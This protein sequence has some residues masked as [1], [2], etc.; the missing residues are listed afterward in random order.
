VEK[1]ERNFKISFLFSRFLRPMLL[2]TTV[3]M[4]SKF[5]QQRFVIL[6]ESSVHAHAEEFQRN[7]FQIVV[8]GDPEVGKSTYLK[9]LRTKEFDS[10]RR[11]TTATDLVIYYIMLIDSQRYVKM[12]FFDMVGQDI[13][14]PDDL[15]PLL[16]KSDAV[17]AFFDA[18][19]PKTFENLSRWKVRLDKTIG[20]GEYKLFVVCNKTDLLADEGEELVSKIDCWR[21]RAT[22]ELGAERFVLVSVIN[23]DNCF[24]L[25][26]ELAE[27][28]FSVRDQSAYETGQK[29]D[30]RKIPAISHYAVMLDEREEK[31]KN[32]YWFCLLL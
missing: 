30:F 2:Q 10:T 20:K 23:N 19:R 29:L 24:N 15:E 6:K 21:R 7:R 25:C 8:A 18:S 27:T 28:I 4:T 11:V 16:G 3:L 26:Y 14:R 17:L 5:D 9:L 1:I 13:N 12:V 32:K 31:K 22:D